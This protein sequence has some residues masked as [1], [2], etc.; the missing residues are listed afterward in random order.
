MNKQP[1]ISVVIPVFNGAD[2]LE[3]AVGSILRQTYKNYEIIVVNDGSND[4][5]RTSKIFWQQ[6][7]IF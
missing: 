7:Q 6:D 5:G 1:K 4:N 3:Q 2:Y